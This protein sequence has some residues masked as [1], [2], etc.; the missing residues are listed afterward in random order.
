MQDV[1]LSALRIGGLYILV[2]SL[3]IIFSD[4]IVFLVFHDLGTNAAWQTYKGLLFVVITGLGLLLERYYSGKTIYL[5]SQRFKWVVENMPDVIVIYDADLRIQ[6]INMAAR[7]ITN[8][9]ESD[10]IGK[11]DEEILPMSLVETYLPTLQEALTTKKTRSAALDVTLPNGETFYHQYTCVPLVTDDG[12][13]R[14]VLSIKHDETQQMRSEEQSRYHALL[15]ENISDAVIGTDLEFRIKAWNR[16]AETIYGWSAEEVMG[17]RLDQLLSPEYEDATPEEVM[18]RFFADG[19]WRGELV[20]RD[21]SGKRIWILRSIN[22]VYDYKGQR[23]GVVCVGKNITARKEAEKK[24]KQRARQLSILHEIDRVILAVQPVDSILHTVLGFTRELIPCERSSVALLDYK[25]QELEIFAVHQS[26]TTAVSPSQRLPVDPQQEQT[27]AQGKYTLINDLWQTAPQDSARQT[28]NQTEIRSVLNVPLIAHDTLIGTLNLADTQPN[29]FSPE[30]VEIAQALAVQVSV[31]IENARLVARLERQVTELDTLHQASQRLQQ[32]LTTEALANEIIHILEEVLTYEYGSVLLVDGKG[33]LVPFAFSLPGQTLNAQDLN[34]LTTS[35]RRVGKGIVEW[36]AEH[37]KSV[38]LGDVRADPRYSPRQE[39]IQSELCVPLQVGRH[40]IGVVNIETTRSDAYTAEDQRLLETLA[41]QM[42]VAIRNSQL[43]ALERDS[44]RRL[45]QL[46][47]YLQEALEA[48]R[49]RI[50]REIHDEF[51]QMLTALKMDTV[52]LRKRLPPDRA[53]LAGKTAEMVELI[54]TA[55]QTVRNLASELRPGLLDDLG[56]VAALEWYAQQFS[57]RTGIVC[58]IDLGSGDIG[59]HETAS[60][61]VFR[62]FQ[63]TLT[64]ITRHAKATYVFISLRQTE[65]GFFMT[66]RDNGQG[67]AH[68]QLRG[69]RSLG[70]TG[71]SERVRALGGTLDIQ[72]APGRGTSLTLKLPPDPLEDNKND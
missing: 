51:G 60:T 18:A 26:E 1:K 71:M 43:L 46:A 55:V 2:A 37:G 19:F 45:R 35:D 15:H 24:L 14:E 53:E 31:S 47:N 29:R 32:A 40:I 16:A 20:Q 56:L 6:Y 7:N 34:Q 10:F 67:M 72:S 13:V 25:R 22:Y 30:D 36:V 11:R 48:E 58:E 70:I 65:G 68:K 41:A 61:A 21:R 52:W 8:R 50:A 38:C 64:N 23:V 42:A 69:K 62:I 49:A 54:D 33:K 4:Q 5:A 59:L 63:E 27:W 17:Q 9:P 57:K 44:Q 28:P 12:A 3:W 66:V 39:D